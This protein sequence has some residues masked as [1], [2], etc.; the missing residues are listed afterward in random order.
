MS[1]KLEFQLKL[2][3][4]QKQLELSF[5]QNVAKITKRSFFLLYS[6]CHQVQGHFHLDKSILP[7]I[8]SLITTQCVLFALIW[9]ISHFEKKNKKVWLLFHCKSSIVVLSIYNICAHCFTS[10][11]RK[12]KRKGT[13]I[14]NY[15][16]LILR[17]MIIAGLDLTILDSRGQCA[18][19]CAT[20][21]L[22]LERVFVLFIDNQ[23][24]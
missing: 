5:F 2:L 12:I 23:Y 21:Y 22:K 3:V 10:K 6:I 24:L 8:E 19:H 17:K 16:N 14:N 15:N 4:Y 7:W 20:K 11:L 18:N 9:G 1:T 13:E